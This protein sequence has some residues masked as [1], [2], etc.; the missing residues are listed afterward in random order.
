MHVEVRGDQVGVLRLGSKHLY[1]LS[2]PAGPTDMVYIPVALSL[3]AVDLCYRGFPVYGRISQCP[4]PDSPA[5]PLCLQTWTSA[6]CPWER[7][8]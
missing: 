3:G 8:G 5:E 7:Q 4:A 6:S 1:L 2:H